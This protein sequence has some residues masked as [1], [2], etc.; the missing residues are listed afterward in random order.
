MYNCFQF[1]K[2]ARGK[3]VVSLYLTAETCLGL[4][5]HASI[6]IHFNS[7]CTTL[8]I[9]NFLYIAYH[10]C[11]ENSVK[12]WIADYYV[13]FVN[14]VCRVTLDKLHLQT[15]FHKIKVY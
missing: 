13:M 4:I 5:Y 2:T 3:Y 9:N 1:H 8:Q 12:T 11:R 10:F 6:T 14:K 7:N 15:K